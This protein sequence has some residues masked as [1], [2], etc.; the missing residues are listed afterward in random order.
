MGQDVA[1]TSAF[2]VLSMQFHHWGRTRPPQLCVLHT[3][4][5]TTSRNSDSCHLGG[6]CRGISNIF[7]GD[8]VT[9][10]VG[11]SPPWTLPVVQLGVHI[12]YY[13]MSRLISLFLGRGKQGLKTASEEKTLLLCL[14]RFSNCKTDQHKAEQQK[15]SKQTFNNTSITYTHRSTQQW[16]TQTVLRTWVY[17]KS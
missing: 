7:P 17:L 5:T 11:E 13:I 3:R 1:Q 12:T 8:S 9:E 4:I 10:V 16:V 14:P 15:K 6:A 2:L